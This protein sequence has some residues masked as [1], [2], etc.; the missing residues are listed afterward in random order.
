MSEL[1]S[2]SAMPWI[3]NVLLVSTRLSALLLMTPVLHAVPLPPTV[4][5]L[6]VLA[7]SAALAMPL[8]GSAATVHDVPQL[9]E[10]FLRELAI[11]ATLG[12]GVLMAFSGFALAGRVIDVQLGFGIGQV[13]DP[14]TRTQVPVITSALGLA[15]VVI[16]FLVNGHHALLR[17]VA[18][19]LGRFPAGQSWSLQDAAGPVLQQVAGLF[20]LGFALA[21]PI[22]LCLLLVEFALG[23]L[24]R[25]LPQANIL[26][27]GMPVKVVA[28]LLVLSFWAGGMGEITSRVYGNLYATWNRL[29]E[30]PPAPAGGSR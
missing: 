5:L 11:G 8:A 12:L 27:L 24:A 28:G 6:M 16:F 4:R 18:Y 25:N 7:L 23:V 19:S 13:F 10:A 1:F 9:F 26:L 15:G 29:F 30:L 14:L 2:A 20:T 17:G 21:A 22:V 3:T